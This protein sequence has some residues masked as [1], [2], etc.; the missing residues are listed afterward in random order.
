[1]EGLVKSTLFQLFPGISMQ[2]FAILDG[3]IAPYILDPNFSNK[4]PVIPSEVGYVNF[5]WKSRKK[6]FYNFDT[7]TSSDPKILEPPV[8][9]IKTQG[10]VPKTKKGNH[11]NSFLIWDFLI[12]GRSLPGAF[13][14]V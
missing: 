3:R 12:Q 1:M 11:I 8:L 13:A 7:L 10:R 9:S 6:Y 4:L 14:C 2:V 5:T